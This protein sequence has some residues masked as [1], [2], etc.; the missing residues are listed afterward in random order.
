MYKTEGAPVNQSMEKK[1]KQ[2]N[3]KRRYKNDLQ[4]L[5][6]K[7]DKDKGCPEW[8]AP[9]SEGARDW[10]RKGRVSSEQQQ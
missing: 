6:C 5:E 9:K 2:N 7:S 1:K 4:Q 8:A 3:E 10:E